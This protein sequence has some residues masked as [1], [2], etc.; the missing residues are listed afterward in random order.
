MG[1]GD[2]KLLE[3]IQEFDEED[4]HNMIFGKVD[5]REWQS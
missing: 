2:M 5:E 4:E 1:I 3:K